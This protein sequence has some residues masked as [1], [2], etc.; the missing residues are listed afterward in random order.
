MRGFACLL[1]VLAAMSC[2]GGQR[3]PFVRVMTDSGRVYYADMRRTL[4]SESGGFLAFRC[5]VTSDMVRLKDGSYR[6]LEC[7]KEEVDARQRQY[8]RDPSKKPVASDYE[9]EPE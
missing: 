1:T 9:P 6:A 5:V 3:S 4:H 7:P 8:L 2:G